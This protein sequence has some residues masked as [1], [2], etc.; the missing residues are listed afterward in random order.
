LQTSVDVFLK[1]QGYRGSDNYYIATRC[2]LMK[3][4]NEHGNS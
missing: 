2:L 3:G 1:N 4:N